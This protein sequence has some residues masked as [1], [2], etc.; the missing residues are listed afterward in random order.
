MTGPAPFPGKVASTSTR[1]HAAARPLEPRDARHLP[2][3]PRLAEEAGDHSP[4]PAGGELV[5]ST[6]GFDGTTPTRAL[7]HYGGSGSDGGPRREKVYCDKWIHDG[8]CAFTQQGCKYKHEMPRG[9]T[10]ARA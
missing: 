6:R 9:R 10:T 2:W 4:G 8:T 7:T 5:L 3:V 1:C